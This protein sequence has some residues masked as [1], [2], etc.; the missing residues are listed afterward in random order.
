MATLHLIN[1]SL[2]DSAAL[3]NCLR[4]ALD[5]DTVL[6]IGNGVYCA[7][8]ETFLR[9][10]AGKIEL[11]WCASSE[12]VVSRGITRRVAEAI[13]LIDDGAFVDLVAQHQPV[14]SWS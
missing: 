1:A 9:I 11:S 13:R 14:V 7:V 6:L 5:G 2:D 10:R 12:D 3:S 8:A 4:A